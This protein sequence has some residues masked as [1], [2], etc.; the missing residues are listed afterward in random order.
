[1]KLFT[2]A[3]IRAADA[4]TIS[5]TPI[6]SIDL[7]ER[8]A[9]ACRDWILFNFAKD[10]LFVILCGTGN[11]GGDG[12]ALARMLHREGYGVKAFLLQ[13]GADRSPDCQTNLER[14]QRSAPAQIDTLPPDTYITDIAA[15]IIII[16]AIFGT[17]LNRAPQ[18]WLARF[19]RKVNEL[20][21]RVIS[22]DI[23]S[24]LSADSLPAAG[25]AVV[26]AEHTLSFQFH[27]RSMLHPEGGR[28]CGHIHVLDIGLHPQFIAATPAN[29]HTIDLEEVRKH[30]RPRQPFT[31]KGTY[32]TAFLAGGSHGMIGAIALATRAASRAGAGKVFVLAPEVGYNILQTLAPEAMC[33]SSGHSYIENIS[34][35]EDATAIGI[36]CGLGTQKETIEALA[37][38]VEAAKDPLVLD[39]D[40]LN[41]IAR[42]PELLSKLPAG[43]ILTPHP[44]EF[45]RLFGP[46]ADSMQRLELAR[47]QAMRCNLYIL[48]KD[49]HSVLIS[50][51]GDCWYNLTGNAGLATAGSGDVLTGIIT[52]LL[53][54]RYSPLA[55]AMLGIYLHGL[56]G[57]LA[58]VQ[59][60]QEA[61]LPTDIIENL[62]KAFQQLS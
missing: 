51:E 7:M 11:N 14:L 38:F 30:Y 13:T 25:D 50:P 45:E 35:H 8:A 36:G 4:Y 1:M 41:I 54:Q 6:A 59:H 21:N 48:L 5:A 61:L 10:S 20:P 44:K 22:I 3:Q 28:C 53:A 56:A 27:K 15:H 31:H 49:R 24:G 34:G 46:T 39:A 17:G 43:S 9:A 12:L 23:P 19:I 18:G 26:E 32:G 33:L 58:A 55:A 42:R 52:G 29:F 16:D 62:G 37:A 57:E 2:A 47:M 40:A 60:S